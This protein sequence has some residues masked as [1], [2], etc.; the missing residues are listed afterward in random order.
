[1]IRYG[2]QHGPGLSI[3]CVNRNVQKQKI[4]VS[5]YFNAS[6]IR[7]YLQTRGYIFSCRQKEWWCRG[8]SRSGDD[9]RRWLVLWFRWRR[10]S[11]SPPLTVI[12]VAPVRLKPKQAEEIV[13][14]SESYSL[15]ESER[16]R[17]KIFIITFQVVSS[18]EGVRCRERLFTDDHGLPLSLLR[19]FIIIFELP[20]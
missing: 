2:F 3:P 19:A 15:E 20:V 9:L 5:N 1:M 16:G 12:I 7:F 17:K 18:D 14:A 13:T 10:R 8:R 4:F 6:V 11:T